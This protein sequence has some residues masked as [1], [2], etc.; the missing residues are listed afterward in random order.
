MS[1]APTVQYLL[2]AAQHQHPELHPSYTYPSYAS[3]TLACFG[4]HRDKST[5]QGT[6]VWWKPH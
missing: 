6:K 5:N 4:L 2:T 1:K 3:S